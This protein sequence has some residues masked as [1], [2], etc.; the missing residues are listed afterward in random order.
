MFSTTVCSQ[1]LLISSRS[2]RLSRLSSL[3]PEAIEILRLSAH[4]LPRNLKGQTIFDY[5]MK[6]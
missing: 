3:F 2:A 5:L 4:H 6:V 1:G